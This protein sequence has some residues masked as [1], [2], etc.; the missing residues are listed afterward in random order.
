MERKHVRLL[1]VEKVL[2]RED[3]VVEDLAEEL[4]LGE[5]LA[6]AVAELRQ[7]L[8]PSGVP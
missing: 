6:S 1:M 8:W 3:L 2:V 4:A 5:E 7:N